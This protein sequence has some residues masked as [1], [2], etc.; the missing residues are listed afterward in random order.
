MYVYNVT[1]KVAHTI[2][3]DW[4]RW[5]REEHI[6]E[7][8]ATGCFDKATILQL[9]EN[10]DEEGATYAVQYRALHHADYERY[11]AEFAPGMRQKGLDKWGENFIA[12]RTLMQI[13][14]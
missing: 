9:L 13:V 6:P 1:I 10:T 2:A 4:L 5:L 7:M 14:D 12:F 11:L 3:A 8:I